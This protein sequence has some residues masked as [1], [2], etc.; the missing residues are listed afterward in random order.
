MSVWT[1]Q[2]E[3]FHLGPAQQTM[4]S[5]G[6]QSPAVTRLVRVTRVII[7]PNVFSHFSIVKSGISGEKLACCDLETTIKPL[8]SRSTCRLVS[9]FYV[10]ILENSFRAPSKSLQP[11]LEPYSRAPWMPWEHPAHFTSLLSAQPCSVM[12]HTERCH[13]K[14]SLAGG[15]SCFPPGSPRGCCPAWCC[16]DG[17]QLS[18]K[19]AQGNKQE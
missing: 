9:F 18:S 11:K 15:E 3:V 6:R 10:L 4:W 12:L 5:T 2:L 19:Q 16:R 13:I 8:L 7:F 1:A 17:M 14:A